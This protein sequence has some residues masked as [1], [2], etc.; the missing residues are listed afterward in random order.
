MSEAVRL[1]VN[2]YVSLKDRHSLEGLREHRQRMR[3][4]LQERAGGAF[5]VSRSVRQCDEDIKIVEDG[6]ARL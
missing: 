1:I 3:K 4:Q 2:A 5:D 6:L